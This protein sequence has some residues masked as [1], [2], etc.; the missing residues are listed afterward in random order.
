MLGDDKNVLVS[1]CIILLCVQPVASCYGVYDLLATAVALSNTGLISVSYFCRPSPVS[2]ASCFF[3]LRWFSQQ[4]RHQPYTPLSPP[5]P[6]NALPTI[7]TRLIT[8]T[9]A[10]PPVAPARVNLY[11]I[12]YWIFYRI[13]WDPLQQRLAAAVHDEGEEDETRGDEA[14]DDDW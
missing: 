10:H 2:I 5:P 7:W 3:K 11:W 9:N 4:R 6:L 12:F 1:T 13:F 8:Q 14:D